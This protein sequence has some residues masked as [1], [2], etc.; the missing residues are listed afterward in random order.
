MNEPESAAPEIVGF[1]ALNVDYIAGASRLSQRLADRVTESTARFEWNREGPVDQDTILR[2]VESLGAAS[3]SYSLGGSAWLTIYSLAQMRVGLRLGYVGVV[4]RVEAP[5]LSFVGQMDDLGI[6]RRWVVR[7]PSRPCGLCLSYI[8]DTDR[9]MLTHPG[10]NFEM[11]RLI[12]ENFEP[13]AEYLASARFVH[14]TSFLDDDTPREV[15]R[16]LARARALNPLLRVSFDPGFTWAERPGPDV[17]GI[18]AM[19]DLLF[20]NYREFKSLGRYAPGERDEVV[21]RRLLGL[22]APGCTVFVTKRYD[23]VEVFHQSPAGIVAQRFEQARPLRETE[24]ED[25]TG[26]GDVFAA[27]VLAS[28]VARRLHVELGAFVGLYLA[29]NKLRSPVAGGFRAPDLS[30]GFLRQAET[31][32][33]EV[34]PGGVCVVHAGNPQCGTVRRFLER[35]CG[36]ATVEL[37]VSGVETDVAAVTA[38]ALAGCGFAVCLLAAGAA[39]PGGRARADQNIVYQAG[40]FQGRY[41]F[42]RVAILVEEGCDTFSNIAGL[43]QLDFRDGAVDATFFELERMLRREGFM[44][45]GRS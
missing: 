12:R 23:V 21:A 36:L 2:A 8:D 9:V 40:V 42:G 4:G 37:D 32:P 39:P 18:L 33:G 30:K 17:M 13:L 41:G 19:T 28:L 1:G 31:P 24:L 20:M 44:A 27:A 14:V 5:G 6:D 16:V 26:A 38:R 10:A 34:A 45:R 7:H 35:D 3:L 29:R 11:G 25:A 15:R 43:I 22:C